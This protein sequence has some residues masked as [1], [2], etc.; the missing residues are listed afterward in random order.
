MILPVGICADIFKSIAGQL[1]KL[2]S[3]LT[4]RHVPLLERKKFLFLHWRSITG[5]HNF[6]DKEESRIKGLSN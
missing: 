5:K 6:S 4:D 2:V 3:V 1:Q